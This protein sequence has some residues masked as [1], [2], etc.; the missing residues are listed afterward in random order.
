MQLADAELAEWRAERRE[1]M[2]ARRVRRAT[3]RLGLSS[4]PLLVAATATG[5]WLYTEALREDRP[6][7]ALV[8]IHVA[9]STIG[10][11]VVTVKLVEH[12]RVRLARRLA[13]G[14]SLMLAA[15]ALPLLVTGV[16]LLLEP[17]SDSRSAY[18]H[19]V[20]ASWWMALLGLH[21]LRYL[22]RSLDAALRGRGSDDQA[23]APFESR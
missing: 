8:W 15:L 5:L 11:A 16:L 12:G 23:R 14:V 7:P 3:S 4:L 13:E 2:L 9:A 17:S 6:S 10:L 18:V 21:L 19:L 20:A 22:S 1:R